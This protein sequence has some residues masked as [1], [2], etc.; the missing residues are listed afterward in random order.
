MDDVLVGSRVFCCRCIFVFMRLCYP[1]PHSLVSSGAGAIVHTWVDV[2]VRVIGQQS[3]VN[4]KNPNRS[5]VHNLGPQQKSTLLP[6]TGVLKGGPGSIRGVMLGHLAGAK[7]LGLPEQFGV[8]RLLEDVVELVHTGYPVSV[9]RGLV[10]SLSC[11]RVAQICRQTV[12][13]WI[14]LGQSL[15]VLDDKKDQR[16]KPRHAQWS[17][18]WQVW[19]PQRFWVEKPWSWLRKKE[20]EQLFILFVLESVSEE[21]S[22]EQQRLKEARNRWRSMI[23]SSLGSEIVVALGEF[24]TLMVVEQPFPEGKKRGQLV[25]D[26]ARKQ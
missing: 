10:H 25:F 14:L 7:M 22:W 2:E 21:T 20:P 6:W 8:A 17:S 13:T 12:R 9:V 26:T 3:A 15:T 11:S 16:Q 19:W 5:W 23:R 1:V 18:S 4:M 24:I